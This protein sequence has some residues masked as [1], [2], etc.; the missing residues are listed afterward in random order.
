MDS[1]RQIADKIAHELSERDIGDPYF[2]N[3]GE[4]DI[5]P[6]IK[7][8]FHPIPV[9]KKSPKIAYI[10]G[11]NQEL[12]GAPE[13][14]AQL[15]R[16]YFNIFQN[17]KRVEIKS[18]IPQRI[19]FL[20]LTNS[21]LDDKGVYFETTLSPVDK[22][23]F[24]YLPPEKYLKGSAKDENIAAASQAGME[25][26][27]SKSR[28]FTEWSVAEH[29]IES[30]LSK[31]DI[32]VRDGSLQTAHTFES[33]YVNEIFSKAIDNG[34]IF[35]GLS[36]TCRLTTTTQMSLI[37]SIQRLAEES[38]MG[39][40]KLWAYYPIAKM[41]GDEHK[42]LIM[43]VKLNG[44]AYSP[45]RFEILR[46]QAE[47]MDDNQIL[48]V[49]SSIA[50]QSNDISLPGYPYGLID[51][52]QWAR[53]KNEEIEAYK[54]RLFSELSKTGYWRKIQPHIRAVDAHDR[55]DEM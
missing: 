35:T 47:N 22:K 7:D 14:S 55:L 50:N 45:F 15:N 1:M 10:D 48:E 49:I 12:L 4:C 44:F 24:K 32:I 2:S 46:E 9:P 19:E 8:N 20:S 43:V 53:V 16:V 6:L 26:M 18:D 34:I 21:K 33:K 52:D 3:H 36:K 30:E 42:A 17:K 38:N 54:T 40:D 39:H 13:Y 23:F 27:A 51:A 31:G 28:R 25:R 29:L 41:K 5:F 11:G 37:A